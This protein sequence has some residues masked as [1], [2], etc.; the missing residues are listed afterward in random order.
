[1]VR[2]TFAVELLLTGVPINQVFAD[3]LLESKWHD[4]LLTAL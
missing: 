3:F 4:P 1:M 2:D